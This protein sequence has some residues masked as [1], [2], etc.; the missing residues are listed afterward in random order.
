MESVKKCGTLFIVATPIGN[1]EDISQRAIR[2]LSEVDI[3]ACEDTRHTKKLLNHFHINTPL[4]S[5][6]REKEQKKG[7]LLLDKIQDGADIALVSDAGT[8]GLSDPGSVL[9]AM[10]RKKNV[11]IVPI[12]GVSALSTALSVA[13]LTTSSFFFS[14]F[15]PAKKEQRKKNFKELAGLAVPLIFYESPHR[16]KKCLSDAENIFGDRQAL[17]FRELTKIHEECLQGTLSQIQQKLENKVRGELVLIILP[18]EQIMKEKPE[19]L[20]NLLRWYRNQPGITLKDAVKS[21]AADLEL[22]RSLVYKNGLEVWQEKTDKDP[23][24]K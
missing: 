17:L 4:T 23:P 12:P 5:Y 24:G 6:Y 7:K 3:I 15:S 20:K 11:P 13:G 10:A 21:I 22:S 9:V 16:I 8:P 2:T 14:G 1:L 19:D 18:S